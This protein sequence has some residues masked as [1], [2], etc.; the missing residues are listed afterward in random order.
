M[1]K[2]VLGKGPKLRDMEVVLPELK[3]AAEASAISGLT[4]RIEGKTKEEILAD[5]I[6]L[7]QTIA[8]NVVSSMKLPPTF[9]FD[10]L[11]G[12]G[13]EGLIKAF[14]GFDKAHGVLFK[15]YASYRVRGEMLDRIREEWRYRNFVMPRVQKKIVEVAKDSLMEEDDGKPAKVQD[16]A[17]NSAIVY[18]LSIDGL[19]INASGR[20]S[21]DPAEELLEEMEYARERKVLREAIDKTLDDLEKQVVE[22]FYVKEMSQKDI[23][24]F[25]QLSR[26][27][28]NRLHSK[29]VN[30]LRTYL[31]ATL[32]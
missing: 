22:L 19:E 11:V 6:P 12:F 24:S 23:A 31:K 18:L 32:V 5:N 3:R 8:A 29:I 9:S 21:F 26:S 16:V 10:D 17:A 25:L 13:M 2:S 7:V 20:S 28:V 30:K 27:K 15:T 4:K 14:A 1:K